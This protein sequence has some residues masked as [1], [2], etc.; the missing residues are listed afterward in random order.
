M[1]GFELIRAARAGVPALGAFALAA[2]LA[3][4]PAAAQSTG[5]GAAIELVDPDTLRVCADPGNMPFSNEAGEGFENAIAEF[6]AKKLGKGISYT[7]FPQGVGFV[8]NTLQ[9]YRCDIVIGY[10]QGG[11][12]VQGTNPYYRSAYVLVYPSGNGLDGIDDLSDPRLKGLKIGVV[13]GTPPATT[14][15]KNG[16]IGNAQ[17][18]HLMV[19]T[20]FDHPVEDMFNDLGKGDIDAAL[21]WGPMAGYY[22]RRL[23]GEYTVL[24]LIHEDG[25]P[26]MTYRITMGVRPSDQEWKRQLNDL[27]REN[28]SEINDILLSY[29]VPLLDEH[30]QLIGPAATGKGG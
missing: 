2:G 9:A 28:Q 17:P 25:G 3:T 29:G 5:L 23:P 18:Y 27:I 16:L 7:Y 14:L 15:A 11:E 21:A 26:R 24:P 1:H 12:L 30:D 8:R 20:R 22:A 19:D 6:V 10:A 4:A 13:A